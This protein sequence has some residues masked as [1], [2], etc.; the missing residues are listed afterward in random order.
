MSMSLLKYY[1]HSLV[2]KL[3][4]SLTMLMLLSATAWMAVARYLPEELPFAVAVILFLI[5]FCGIVVLVFVDCMKTLWQ[6]F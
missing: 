5:G 4:F 6:V 3:I 1:R 2:Y